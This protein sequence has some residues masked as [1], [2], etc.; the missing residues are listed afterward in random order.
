MVN[1]TPVSSVYDEVFYRPNLKTEYASNKIASF[2]LGYL[3]IKNITDVGCGRGTWLLAFKKQ[4]LLDLHGIDGNWNS[5]E[6]MVDSK[7]IFFEENLAD[8]IKY[9]FK[10]DLCISL[11]VAEHIPYKNSLDF[12][13][14]LTNISDLVLFS[15]AY[16]FQ[17]GTGHINEQKHSYW[18]NIFEHYGYKAF[19]IIHPSFWHD[20][21]ID[22]WYKQNIFLYVKA[23][24]FAFNSITEMGFS[25]MINLSFCD[26]IH[27]DLYTQKIDRHITLREIANYILPA[28]INSIKHRLDK[29]SKIFKK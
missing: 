23:D 17:G 24:S 1:K 10:R 21:D 27:P 18:A 16:E 13:R 9:N 8:N 25:P 22:F 12:I 14:T 15:A 6:K 20:S 2:L 28:L 3:K 29:W 19:D 26:A 4:G 7:I 11:E 5:Q